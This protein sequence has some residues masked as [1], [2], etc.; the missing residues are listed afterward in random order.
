MKNIIHNN[1]GN[2]GSNN[3]KFPR[4]RRLNAI[5]NFLTMGLD[6]N[7]IIESCPNL[8]EDELNYVL[9]YLASKGLRYIPTLS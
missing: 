6:Y 9:W 2:W 3:D 7:D 8:S 1:K 5:Y 4:K